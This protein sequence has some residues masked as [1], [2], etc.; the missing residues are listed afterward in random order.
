MEPLPFLDTLVQ[1]N[2]DKT[3]LV[4]KQRT[5]HYLKYTSHNP[6]SAKQ[7]AITALFD[8]ADN[9]VS[10]E[11]DKIEEKHHSLAALQQNGY[12]KEFIQ[13]TVKSTTGEKNSHE[14]AQKKNLSKPKASTYLT[15]KESVNS[16]NDYLI[17]ATSK[18]HSTPRQQS[19]LSKPKGPIP[20][21]DRNDAA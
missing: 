14:S 21:E 9:V 17:N 2:Y 15:S 6:T 11:K 12:P 10:N 4:E 20:K 16:L 8:R 3:V 1:R 13:R 7:S 19:L 18:Q 5:N